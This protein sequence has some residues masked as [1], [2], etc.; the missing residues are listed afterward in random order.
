LVCSNER[1]SGVGVAVG[2]RGVGIGGTG[3]G[4]GG[5]AV[6]VGGSAVGAGGSGVSVGGTV[7]LAQPLSKA[8]MPITDK[9]A[10]VMLFRDILDLLTSFLTI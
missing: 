1:A 9:K 6:G 4:V 7:G 8:S 3:V 5:S 2:G 10:P